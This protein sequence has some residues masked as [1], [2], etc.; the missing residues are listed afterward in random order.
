MNNNIENQCISLLDRVSKIYT[1]EIDNIN[2]YKFKILQSINEI[3]SLN[4]KLL[5]IDTIWAKQ[6]FVVLNQEQLRL[7]SLL[8]KINTLKTVN[9]QNDV[10]NTIQKINSFKETLKSMEENCEKN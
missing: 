4:K 2:I 3:K 5:D 1:Y 8:E 10:I 7:E 6:Y 9:T